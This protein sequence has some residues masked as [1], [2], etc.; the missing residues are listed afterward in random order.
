MV[1]HL[2]LRYRPIV[3]DVA[4]SVDQIQQWAADDAQAGGTRTRAAE[5]GRRG[6]RASSQVVRGDTLSPLP[7]GE[8]PQVSRG[9]KLSPQ[10]TDPSRGD[11]GGGSGVTNHASRGDSGVTRT[12]I[13]PSREP[14]SSSPTP[15]RAPASTHVAGGGRA[16]HSV[17]AAVDVL[18][19]PVRDHPSVIPSA[20]ARRIQ[21]LDQLGWPR[22]EIRRRLAGVE[23][24]DAPGAAALTRLDALTRQ[25]P[26]R[27]PPKRPAWCG[28]CDQRTRLR[29]DPQG[30][31][32]PYRCPECHPSTAAASRSHSP[33]CRSRA[34]PQPI[35]E[36]TRPAC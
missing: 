21:L 17:A 12:V 29:E 15:E 6:G 4:I 8:S 30:D 19:E 1:D 9:D 27:S 24:A 7:Q 14:S 26:P 13:E 33:T 35:D 32:R 10:E 23:T 3:Y 31:D 16:D 5:A 22:T 2:D 20:I 18:P 36:H 34:T 25:D 11:N 28:Q